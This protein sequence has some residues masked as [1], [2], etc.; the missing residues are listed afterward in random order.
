MIIVKIMDGLGNQMFQYALAKVFQWR[1]ADVRIDTSLY[2][3]KQIH[4][5]YELDR[6]FCTDIP[7][8]SPSEISRLAGPIHTPHFKLLKR[9]LRRPN[10][11][12]THVLEHQRSPDLRRFMPEI[13]EL[14]DAYLEGYWQSERY[15]A[16]FR[17]QI[18]EL[19]A[20]DPV[21]LG[22]VNLDL[23]EQMK[24][25]QSVSIHFR[26]GD[27][28]IEKKNRKYGGIATDD[29]YQKAIARI[30]AKLESPR[31]FVFSN[32][33]ERVKQT[34][35]LDDC[36]FVSHNTGES[37]YMDLFLMASCHNNIIANSSFS[38]WGAYLNR[39][40]D[41]IVLAPARWNNKRES[42]DIW[43][44]DWIKIE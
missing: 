33:I 24:G 41:K 40:P 11:K 29:Y 17:Q 37:S 18:Q 39:N 31:F 21:Q 35:N 26:L 7:E 15:F 22:S 10:L 14:R 38:W 12:S 4:M 20:F 2:H 19:F 42:P 30:R 9:L 27:Y 28:S 6:I 23:A 43:C 36:V 1:G 5:G 34:F 13:F 8:A 44:Q 25:C 32:N 16:G 3:K